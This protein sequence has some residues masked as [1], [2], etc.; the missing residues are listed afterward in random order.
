ME[1]LINNLTRLGLRVEFRV[2]SPLVGTAITPPS[3]P[4]PAIKEFTV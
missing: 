3:L 4:D 2:V 1:L